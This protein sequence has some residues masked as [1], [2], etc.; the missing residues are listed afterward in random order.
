[1]LA[2]PMP[3]LRASYMAGASELALTTPGTHNTIDNV[4]TTF[5]LLLL[6][7]PSPFTNKTGLQVFQIRCRP[8]P[9]CLYF[10]IRFFCFVFAPVRAENHHSEE[11]D[12]WHYST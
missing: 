4:R 11:L 6:P 5:F 3:L 1:M 9:G 12:N 10:S 8:A 7:I 2:P